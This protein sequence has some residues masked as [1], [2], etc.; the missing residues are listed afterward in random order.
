MRDDIR[1][2]LILA[3]R[4]TI[5]DS[6]GYAV[7]V[8]EDFLPDGIGWTV[9]CENN[10]GHELVMS[11]ETIGDVDDILGWA[12]KICREAVD[13][14]ESCRN[15]GSGWPEFVDLEEKYGKKEDSEK[16]VSV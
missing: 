14:F 11:I 7:F 10:K 2:T 15:N 4:D 5:G 16:Q 12:S 13:K 3:L 6:K 9:V 1:D 8:I